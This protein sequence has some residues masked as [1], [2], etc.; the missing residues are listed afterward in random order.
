MRARRV[1]GHGGVGLHV[2][3]AGPED[4]PAILLLHGWSQHHLSWER[5]LRGDLARRFRLVA[6]DLRGHGASDKPDAPGAYDNP[7]PWAG[8]VAALIGTL[9][10]AAPVVVGWSMG[11]WVA[12]D[13]LGG[14][15][16]AGIS[17][18]VLIGSAA[19]TGALADPAIVAKRRPDVAAQGMYSEDQA[20]ALDAAVA[21]VRACFSAPIGKRDLAR[22]VG[23]NMLVPPAVRRAARLRDNDYR[24]TLGALSKPAMVIQGA[25]EKV[26][27]PEAFRETVDAL[28]NPRV[29]IYPGCG[30][31]PFREDPAR[32][33]ADLD[34]FAATCFGTAP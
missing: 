17:G 2:A 30:H 4:A 25:D 29:E 15:G 21:F 33:D 3:E 14:F 22:M 11:G 23:F 28:R 16:D 32:F 20:A 31:A 8:D 34:A 9:G 1:E 27:V 13:Y 5:T 26:C 24:A 10:P 18:L 7:E 19:R 6:P 12:C